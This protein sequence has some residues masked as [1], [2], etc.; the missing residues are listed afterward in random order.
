MCPC[1]SLQVVVVNFLPLDDLQWNSSAGTGPRRPLPPARTLGIG[2]NGARFFLNL[3]NNNM[4]TTL[5][6][7]LFICSKRITRLQRDAAVDKQKQEWCARECAPRVDH[8]HGD[9]PRCC[10]AQRALHAHTYMNRALNPKSRNV[11]NVSFLGVSHL[12]AQHSPGY[13][14]GPQFWPRH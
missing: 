7:R 6:V 14:C 13:S 4:L 12:P 11:F 2:A 3:F 1:K 10:N 9:T 5:F 8:Q